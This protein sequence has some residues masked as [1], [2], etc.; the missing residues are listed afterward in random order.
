MASL[1]EAVSLEA[2]GWQGSTT[3][4]PEVA[5]CVGMSFWKRRRM[6]EFLGVTGRKP[7]FLQNPD[8]AVRVARRRG[9]SIAVWAS[10]EPAGLAEAARAAG[11]PLLRVEDG[12]LRSVGLGADF[13]AP[14]SIVVDRRGIYYDPSRESDLEAILNGTTFDTRLLDRARRLIDRIVA[15]GITKYNVGQALPSLDVAAGRQKILVPGQVEDDRSVVLGQAGVAGNLAL[16][17][18][19][20][21]ARPDAFIVYKPHPDVDAGHRAG[22]VADAVA[23][24]LADRVVRDVSSAAL[25]AATDAVHTITSLTG[26]EA[27]LRGRPVVAYGR[28]FYSGWGLTTDQAAPLRHRR[29]LCLDELVAGTLIVYPRYVDPASGKSCTP[30][31]LL[32]RFTD[33]AAWSPGALVRARQLQGRLMRRL[34]GA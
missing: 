5:V 16:L 24:R 32:D 13:T 2:T 10:R 20:R 34:R 25:I 21:S 33:P 1:A 30:E 17:Q 15:A 18:A 23:L 26:F 11:I 7:V 19:V 6:T 31:Q 29:P 28:P 3:G 8:A 12:F 27:L 9:G 14:A 4:D 22:A